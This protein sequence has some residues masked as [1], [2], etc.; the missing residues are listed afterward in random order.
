MKMARIVQWNHIHTVTCP[1]CGSTLWMP[2]TQ[3]P[4]LRRAMEEVEHERHAFFKALHTAGDLPINADADYNMRQLR[5]LNR[6][7]RRAAELQDEA[8]LSWVD[9]QFSKWGLERHVAYG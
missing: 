5:R 6:L 9:R 4:E 3:H 8:V 7:Q 2:E 1:Q